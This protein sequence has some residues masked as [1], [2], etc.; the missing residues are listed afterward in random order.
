MQ[1]IFK[2]KAKS[3]ILI[4]NNEYALFKTYEY[5]KNQKLINKLKVK[6]FP[7][8]C[9]ILNFKKLNIVFTKFNIE[10][11]FHAAAYKHVPLV[12]MNVTEAI[13]N[14]ILE[15]KILLISLNLKLNHLHSF[16]VIKLFDQ[17]VCG[18]YKKI[19]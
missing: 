2:Y 16:Q 1:E 17:Q 9:S 13:Q 14:N 10:T 4:D 19:C 8:I 11:I 7:L 12:E 18:C 6:L 3:I 5:L 15:H